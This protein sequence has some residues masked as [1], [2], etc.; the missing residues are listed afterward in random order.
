MIRE[1]QKYLNGFQVVLD[2]ASIYI[3]FLAAHYIKF[4]I[5]PGSTISFTMKQSLQL[6]TYYVLICEVLYSW[7][8][9]YTSHRLKR[10]K[11]E[12]VIIVKSNLLSLLIFIAGLYVIKEINFSRQVLNLFIVL[13][14]TVTLGYRFILR[15]TL[16]TVRSLKLNQ[17]H[18]LVVGTDKVAK[19]LIKRIIKHP[20]WGYNIVGCVTVT[21]DIDT[22]SDL[23]TQQ[24]TFSGFPVLGCLDDL[25]HII[26]SNYLDFVLIA[27]DEKASD[28]LGDIIKC[29]EKNGVKTALVPYYYKYVAAKSEIDNLDG[30]PLINTRSI[31][32]DNV[33]KAFIKRLTDILFSIFAIIIT[34][35]LL[36]FCAL[37]VKFTSPG[38]VL[39]KQE[40][41]GL[42]RK[43]FYM[44]KFRSMR[45][46]TKEFEA[47]KWTTKDDPRKTWWGNIMR[48]TSMDE[49]PQFFNVLKGEMSVIGPRPERPY[50][51][52][53]FKDEIPR[54]M[55]K[56]QVRPG[57]T[58]WAQVNGLRGDTSIE[59][60][61]DYD[62]DY[63]E[64][65]T[66]GLDVQI[67]FLTIF[68]GLIN[69]NAY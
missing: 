4:Y 29:C 15:R 9:L 6:I 26:T 11:A 31:P 22:E 20:Y 21:K 49:L 45:V 61:I 48:K 53:K 55:I 38:P 47:D 65:W 24:A 23:K 67:I 64:N 7:F 13:A 69:K 35:P 39:Y 18:C 36:I 51:V 14:P 43:P 60:R 63:I 8:D 34:S 56:H 46:Q 62:L 40:R 2:V 37:M 57:I 16:R 1:N 12:C 25:E 33:F 27:T 59:E 68:K 19:D 44:Y 30:M 10:F 52:E 41:I 50:F 3:A 17:K 54:Y 5:I 58:G 42:N 32:L 66:Y 28:S